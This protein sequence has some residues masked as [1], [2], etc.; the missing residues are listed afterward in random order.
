MTDKSTFI[1]T[2]GA[3]TNPNDVLYIGP[4]IKSANNI[5]NAVKKTM[6]TKNREDPGFVDVNRIKLYKLE[7]INFGDI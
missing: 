6:E 3:F 1:V 2:I 5:K 7:E 4:C